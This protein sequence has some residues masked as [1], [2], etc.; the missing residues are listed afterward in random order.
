MAKKQ[1]STSS[2]ASV[3]T[4]ANTEGG[5]ARTTT[6][7]T[8]TTT[9]TTAST[10]ASTKTTKTS[11]TS[12]SSTSIV[13]LVSTLKES[14][15]T[16]TPQSI[17]LIDAYLLFVM[18]TGIVQFLYVIAAGT[19]PYNA[20]LSGFI[21]SVGSFVLAVNLRIQVNPL[22]STLGKVYPERAFAEFAFASI[23][24]LIFSINFVG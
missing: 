5:S 3:V 22:N 21:A 17:K 1:V 13:A 8:T 24:L 14:Y 12:K 16:T 15:L 11:K 19:F 9:K 23:V 4:T 10:A 6:T 7:T 20:F 2:S 18:I